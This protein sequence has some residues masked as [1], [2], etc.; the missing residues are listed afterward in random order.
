MDEKSIFFNGFPEGL[1]EYSGHLP[2]IKTES[3]IISAT[4]KVVGVD[5]LYN[6]KWTSHVLDSART[7]PKEFF[8]VLALCSDTVKSSGGTDNVKAISC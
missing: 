5:V 4:D 7:L 8:L 2:L 6:S 1:E 3:P